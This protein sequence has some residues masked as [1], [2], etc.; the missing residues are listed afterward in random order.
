MK[1]SVRGSIESI[2]DTVRGITQSITDTTRDFTQSRLSRKEKEDVALDS[3]ASDKSRSSGNPSVFAKF[4]L[5]KGAALLVAAL[6]TAYV[7]ATQFTSAPNYDATYDGV[8]PPKGPDGP[9]TIRKDRDDAGVSGYGVRSWR[10]LPPRSKT[11]FRGA[12]V[13]AKAS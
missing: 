5:S 4:G 6:V 13:R 2:G 10:S 3:F 7:L 9:V 12:G 11:N 8:M 1:L